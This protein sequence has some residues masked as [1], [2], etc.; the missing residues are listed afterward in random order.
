VETMTTKKGERMTNDQCRAIAERAIEV[1]DRAADLRISEG[2]GQREQA[3]DDRR[4]LAAAQAALDRAIAAA[5]E[6]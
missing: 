4:A 3:R 1:K 6:R 2:K 5:V